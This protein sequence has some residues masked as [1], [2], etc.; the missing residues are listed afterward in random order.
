MISNHKRYYN[1]S[2]NYN[3]LGEGEIDHVPVTA[4]VFNEHFMG[5]DMGGV[6]VSGHMTLDVIAALDKVPVFLGPQ[7]LVNV[8]GEV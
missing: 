3:A 6:V 5:A 4:L 7:L 2:L 1:T 8:A